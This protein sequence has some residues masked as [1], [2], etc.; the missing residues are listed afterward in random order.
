MDGT[1]ERYKARLVVKGYT[2]RQGLDYSKTFFLVAKSVSVR[3]V[4]ALA[5]V[6]GWFSHQ[7][8]VNNTFLHGN[9]DE[10][11]YMCLPLGFHSKGENLVCKFKKS[12][13]GHKQ[14]SRQWFEKFSTT[15]L[16]M[17]FVQSK[18]DYSF[19]TYTQ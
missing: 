16:E 13:Y 4:L 6:K 19:F 15:I 7:S 3:I 1:I 10:E 17:G 11:V 9:L 2:Q 5:T 12:L 18:F 14:A 8:D